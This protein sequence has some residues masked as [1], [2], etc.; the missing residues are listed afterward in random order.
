MGSKQD[1]GFRGRN[2]SIQMGKPC[3]LFCSNAAMGIHCLPFSHGI[4]NARDEK[5]TFFFLRSV[6]E[7][8]R[9]TVLNCSA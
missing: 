9:M 3:R 4:E 5:S 2:S 7:H 6:I 8:R 1:M